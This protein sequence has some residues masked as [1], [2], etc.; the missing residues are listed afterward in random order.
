MKSLLSTLLV[1]ASVFSLNLQAQNDG[2]T[3]Y[4]TAVL[5]FQERGPGMEGQ[6]KN[7][8]DIVFAN[9]VMKPELILVDRDQ[10]DKLLKEAELNL[11]GMVER[12]Q[13]NQIGQLVGAKLLITGSV[14]MVG[15]NT[16]VVARIIG[17]ETSRMLGAKAS[18]DKDLD[19]LAEDLSASIISLLDEKVTELMPAAKS[20]DDYLADLKSTIGDKTLPVLHVSIKEE[21]VSRRAIDP[22]AE[23]EMTLFAKHVGATVKDKDG[24][25]VEVRIVGEGFSEFAG[26]INNLTSVKARLEVKAIG[27]DG[28]VL[29]ID[30]QT[31]VRVDLTELSAGKAALQEA[32]AM[33][34]MRMLPKL[35]TD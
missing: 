7:V 10:L 4:P 2:T 13:A 30:R 5:S 15:N 16:Y 17:T 25:D 28:E 29:A 3:Y 31:V 33:I 8:A 20:R 32:A 27:D 12:D 11:S 21:H 19:E 6:G 35:A 23:T 14:F 34:A 24:R 9:L 26:R 18:G 1:L 22:A